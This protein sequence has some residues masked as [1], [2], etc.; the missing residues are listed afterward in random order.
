M[1]GGREGRRE[2]GGGSRGR[3]IETRKHY[4]PPRVGR[5]TR[6]SGAASGRGF[7]TTPPERNKGPRSKCV[8]DVSIVGLNPHGCHETCD[9]AGQTEHPTEQLIAKRDPANCGAGGVAIRSASCLYINGAIG[10]AGLDRG[11]PA[12]HSEN[13]GSLFHGSGNRDRCRNAGSVLVPAN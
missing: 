3:W 6:H 12:A 13:R 2:G 10:E 9:P 5:D 7:A 4:P 11:K 8:S 1:E